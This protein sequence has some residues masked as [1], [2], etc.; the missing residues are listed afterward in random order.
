MQAIFTKALPLETFIRNVSRLEKYD[1]SVISDFDRHG[2]IVATGN[3]QS[4]MTLIGYII[5]AGHDVLESVSKIDANTLEYV[6]KI[7]SN[8]F[9]LDFVTLKSGQVLAIDSEQVALYSSMDDFHS[10]ENVN[11][12]SINLGE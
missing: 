2:R 12:Q 8:A 6:D 3:V 4:V 11:R 1:L 10:M 5:D 7:E 9:T